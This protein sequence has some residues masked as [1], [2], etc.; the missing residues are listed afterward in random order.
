MPNK[1]ALTLNCQLCC[2]FE[3]QLHESCRASPISSHVPMP[4]KPSAEELADAV[5]RNVENGTY[6]ESEEVVTAELSGPAIPKLLE[7]LKQTKDHVKV[8]RSTCR[9]LTLVADPVR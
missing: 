5:I 7:N 1:Q 3:L 9:S 2:S 8:W 6:P 4:P